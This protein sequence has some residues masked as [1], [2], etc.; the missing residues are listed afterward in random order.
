MGSEYPNDVVVVLMLLSVTYVD[1]R[2]EAA[3]GE[4]DIDI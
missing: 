4:K 2:A 1:V 3:V